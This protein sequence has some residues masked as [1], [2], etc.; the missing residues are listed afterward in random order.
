MRK[1]CST[2]ITKRKNKMKKVLGL[3]I[4]SVLLLSGCGGTSVAS[5]E[6]ERTVTGCF[7]AV[8]NAKPCGT[9][10][11]VSD[12][13]WIPE[14]FNSYSGDNDIAWRW[15][16]SSEFSGYYEA[17]GLMIIPR[18]GCQNGLYAELNVLDKND[19]I[20]GYTNDSL[21]YV[22]AMQK[23][24]LTFNLLEDDGASAT[25]ERISCY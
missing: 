5:S 12:D 3:A 17:W 10:T 19:V 16:K 9:I 25:I 8:G 24:K 14:G 7:D 1:N 13:S 4:A 2:K 6:S 23:A 21:S 22:G 18:Y 15:L 11:T 20:V